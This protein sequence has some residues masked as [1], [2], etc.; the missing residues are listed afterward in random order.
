M[1]LLFGMTTFAASGGIPGTTT[2]YSTEGSSSADDAVYSTKGGIWVQVDENTWTM[3]KDGDRITDVTLVKK[4]DQWEYLFQTED[5]DAQYYGWEESVPNGYKVVGK[6]ERKDPAISNQPDFSITNEEERVAEPE[7]GSLK[8]SKVVTGEG[9]DPSQNFLFEINLTST[10]TALGDKLKG[11]ITFGDV[12]FKD[13]KATVYLKDNDVVELRN[14][15]AGVT[16]DI[17]QKWL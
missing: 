2:T 12:N 11:S 9:A 16:W 10:N 17:R 6:G 5:P 8:L 3:D 15:P 1:I 13:G 14:I 4:G 7:Y